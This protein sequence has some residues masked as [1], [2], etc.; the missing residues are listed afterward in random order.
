MD[1]DRMWWRKPFAS[2]RGDQHNSKCAGYAGGNF[3]STD[4]RHSF[5]DHSAILYRDADRAI[6]V[7]PFRVVASG[8]PL[9][10]RRY[11]SYCTKVAIPAA[12]CQRTWQCTY[13]KP[14]LL[15]SNATVTALRGGTKTVS[16]RAPCK[17]RPLIS[18][19]WKE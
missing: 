6:N 13:H 5:G 12:K 9:S 11:A 4:L 16:L 15:A 18:V 17:A 1:D 19:T 7:G 2:I 14:G 3:D 8:L 10:P